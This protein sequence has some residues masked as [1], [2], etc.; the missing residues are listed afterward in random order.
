MFGSRS[1]PYG[2]WSMTGN[3]VQFDPEPGQN[4]I[5]NVQ[6]D[7]WI[8]AERKGGS[9][10]IAASFAQKLESQPGFPGQAR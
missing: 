9:F 7:K 8:A 2:G 6:T 1:W 3:V 5:M 4:F 10:V